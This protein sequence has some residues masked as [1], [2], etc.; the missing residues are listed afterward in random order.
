M[1]FKRFLLEV[2]VKVGL[3]FLA[4]AVAD[5]IYQKHILPKR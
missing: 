4:I 1:I 3:F 2:I 5:Y